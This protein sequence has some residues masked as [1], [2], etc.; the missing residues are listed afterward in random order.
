[1]TDSIRIAILFEYPSLN[2][3]E[4][5]MLAVID[6][7][8]NQNS[9]FEFVAIA[10]P[11]GPLATALSHRKIDVVPFEQNETSTTRKAPELLK[12]EL[13]TIVD[14]IQPGILHA[15]SLAMGRLTGS[16]ADRL[17]CCCL[18]HLR[19]IMRISKAAMATAQGNQISHLLRY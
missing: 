10:P 17:S 11:S 2:G 12:N 7:L 18:S 14:R 15:N 13:Q 5:S 1:M 3:G 6:E 16:I 4:R 19:D 9:Q 8:S